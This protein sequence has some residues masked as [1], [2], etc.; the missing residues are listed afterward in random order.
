MTV[1]ERA[2][3]RSPSK[4]RK[5]RKVVVPWMSPQDRGSHPQTTRNIPICRYFQDAQPTPWGSEN[6]GSKVA[7]Q[8]FSRHSKIR[9]H[10]GR[11]GRYR[12]Q[13]RCQNSPS[14]YSHHRTPYHQS[15]AVVLQPYFRKTDRRSISRYC[16][17]PWFHRP[18]KQR[19]PNSCHC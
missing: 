13:G 8:A 17:Q 16:R 10:T 9:D 6:R 14:R 5:F 7:N 12:R 4:S 18:C 3:V 1:L 11:T 19:Q 2:E 15:P